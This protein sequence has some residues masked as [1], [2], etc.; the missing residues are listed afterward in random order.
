MTAGRVALPTLLAYAPAA[1][2]LGAPLFFVQFFVLKF[3]TD[4]L[5]LGPGLVGAIFAVAKFWDAALDPIVGTWSDRLRSRMGRRRPF[6][7]AG[8]PILVA[9]F[10]ALWSPPLE[11]SPGWTAAWLAVSLL[12]FFAGF[13]IYAIPHFALGAELTDDHHD[14]SRVYGTRSAAFMLALLPAFAAT[15]LVNNAAQPRMTA[16]ILA[17]SAS[18]VIAAMLLAPL[19]V[20]EREEFSRREAA[21]SFRALADVLR[22]PHARRILAVQFID[23]LGLS[24]LGALAPYVAQ[25][26]LQRTDLIASLPA[27]YTGCLL[28]SI[29]VWVFASGRFGKRPTWMLAMTGVALSFGSTVFVGA[30]D[31]ALMVVLLACAGFFAG[32][33]N[34]IGASMLADVIDADEL[35][36]GHRKEGAYTAA[37]LFAFQVGG[38]IMVF[39]VGLGLELSGFRPNQEQT[40]GAAWAMRG[41]FAGAP[42]VTMLTGAFL[43]RRYALDAHEHARIREALGASRAGSGQA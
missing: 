30:N 16:A 27:V 13:S 32:C 21:T 28:V 5:L 12:G 20:R 4:V 14:R 10:L 39:L 43:L 19:R 24:V 6:M 15:Q 1:F 36:T 42:L 38:G 40:A 11:L 3:A 7:L 23:S 37:F 29:P 33:G 22:N 31:V 26:V 8:I 9:S 17:G 2:A 41:L 34:P 35:A 18:P 25:Y